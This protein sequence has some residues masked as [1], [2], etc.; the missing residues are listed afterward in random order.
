MITTIKF[1]DK[2]ITTDKFH[3]VVVHD[4]AEYVKLRS[5]DAEYIEYATSYWNKIIYDNR[6][7]PTC[8]TVLK[9]DIEYIKVND[10]FVYRQQ[11]PTIKDMIERNK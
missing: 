6:N 11:T 10:M 4:D 8:V 7:I 9:A 1:K 2:T 3:S 5:D